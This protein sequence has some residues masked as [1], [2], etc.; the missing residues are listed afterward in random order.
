[1]SV[2]QPKDD[3]MINE[4]IP[5]KYRKPVYF[6]YAMLGVVLGAID[7]GFQEADVATPTWVAVAITVYL[8]VG[9]AVG[10]TA[11]VH[12]V[13]DPDRMVGNT[14]GTHLHFEVDSVDIDSLPEEANRI[15]K[16]N[17]QKLRSDEE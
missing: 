5:A 1:M 9:G 3:I 4:M 10:L 16:R 8:F 17:R 7:I 14:T 15:I 13:T 11:G 2:Q 12:T 6:G